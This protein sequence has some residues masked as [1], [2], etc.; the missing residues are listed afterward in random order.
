MSDL[1]KRIRSI[2]A[3]RERAAKLCKGEE[4]L[5]VADLNLMLDDQMDWL[6]LDLAERAE[7]LY[8]GKN[9]P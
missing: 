6:A 1:E 2:L 8:F 9:P 7:F 3:G 5:S 4:Q